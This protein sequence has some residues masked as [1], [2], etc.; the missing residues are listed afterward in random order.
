M[1]VAVGVSGGTEIV[2]RMAQVVYDVNEDNDNGGYA[3]CSLDAVTAY[4]RARQYRI[5]EGFREY[6]PSLINFLQWKYGQAVNLIHW[7]GEHIGLC[8]SGMSQGDHIA[9]LGFACAFQSLLLDLD[10]LLKL[11]EKNF[12]D[13]RPVGSPPVLKGS[14]RANSDDVSVF[15][16]PVIMNMILPLIPAIYE[17]HDHC[18]NPTKS[19]CIGRRVDLIDTN[20]ETITGLKKS[21]IG[22]KS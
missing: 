13:D 9:M 19:F 6:C 12:D 18:M 14:I 4:Q 10:K 21:A 11:A 7:T 1:Q 16:A 17:R 22:N 5:Y 15:A 8:E 2:A 3:I 20:E